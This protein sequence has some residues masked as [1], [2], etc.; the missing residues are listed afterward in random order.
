[1][2][3][4]QGGSGKKVGRAAA[5]RRMGLQA[6]LG[7]EFLDLGKMENR[8]EG[9]PIFSRLKTKFGKNIFLGV[10]NW[11]ANFCQALGL[12]RPGCWADGLNVVLTV[13][14]LTWS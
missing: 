1:M 8:R 7:A 9:N 2:I 6:A 12:R 10:K 4:R 13:S 5:N 14:D 3:E 11:C